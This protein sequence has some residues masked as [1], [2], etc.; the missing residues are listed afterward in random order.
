MTVSA[1]SLVLSGGAA[2]ADTVA[3]N[4]GTAAANLSL[5]ASERIGSLTGVAGTAVTLGVNTL[6]TGDATNTS[7]AG[8]IGGVGGALTKVG[9]GTFTLSGANT[10]SGPVTVSAGSLALSG[11]AALADSVAVSLDTATAN[12][13]LNASERIG[14]L[15][16]VVST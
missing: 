16:G 13:T 12:L 15:A 6:T 8:V 2:L 14:S 1:G 7:Y 5:T 10:F 9:S 3:V 4:L 11:G